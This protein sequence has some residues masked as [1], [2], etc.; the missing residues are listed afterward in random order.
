VLVFELPQARR[1]LQALPA[2]TRLVDSHRQETRG[3]ADTPRLKSS[4][5]EMNVTIENPPNSNAPTSI[6]SPLSIKIK[7]LRP[8]A[9]APKRSTSR[10]AGF[11]LYACIDVPVTLRPGERRL[12]PT[13]VAILLPE[14]SVGLCC[15]R[16]GIARGDGITVLNGPGIHDEDYTG[17]SNVLL[18]N[19]GEVEY[20]IQPGDRVAQL[21][22]VPVIYAEV[23]IVEDVPVTERGT[24]G[25]GS[26]GK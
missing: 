17:E 16:S 6:K 23:A 25:F 12:I 13:G 8:S 24:G 20:V 19:L 14:N 15:P 4:R 22:I 9:K 2:Q 11:D 26:T 1:Q 21:V 7:L 10:S 5:K 3:K 18:I